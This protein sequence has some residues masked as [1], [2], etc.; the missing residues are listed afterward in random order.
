MVVPRTGGRP[1]RKEV[2]RDDQLVGFDPMVPLYQVQKP[3]AQV[4]LVL[5]ELED[6]HVVEED[7]REDAVEAPRNGLEHLL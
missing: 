7:V 3:L 6:V 2:G 5:E 4:V 1:H